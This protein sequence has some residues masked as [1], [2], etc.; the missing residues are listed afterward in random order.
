MATV[1]GPWCRTR[2]FPTVCKYCA[3]HV[4][5]FSCDCGSALFFDEL[6]TPWPIHQC[7]KF[8]QNATLSRLGQENLSGTV[9]S[10]LDDKKTEAIAQLIERNIERNYVDAIKQATCVQELSPKQSSWIVR[11]DPYHNC[12]TSEQGIITEIIWNAKIVTKAGLAAGS[13]GIS[14]LGT[15]AEIP[16]VQITI[17]TAALAEDESEN[18][19]FTFFV[20]ESVAKELS[21]FKG[22]F[23]FAE[24]R[25]IVISS[26]YPIWVCEQLDDFY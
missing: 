2:T 25:G 19:S 8:V 3:E 20:E 13:L 15:Y 21:I 7:G 16:L 23:V 24:L 6:G 12:K 9:L 5:Y 1:H 17:H 26:K 4:F 11:Q 10:Y 22:H 14:M 18:F